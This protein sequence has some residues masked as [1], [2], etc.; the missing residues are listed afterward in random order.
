[1]KTSRAKRT[2]A[3]VRTWGPEVGQAIL[4]RPSMAR[5][6]PVA[7]AATAEKPAPFESLATFEEL[8]MVDEVHGG[9]ERARNEP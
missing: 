3:P 8:T 2:G 6:A 9:V 4:A 5:A 7:R 1:M